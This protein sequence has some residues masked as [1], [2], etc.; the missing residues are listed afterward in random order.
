[1]HTVDA[2]PQPAP[3]SAVGSAWNKA[4]TY[5]ETILTPWASAYL[6]E[7]LETISVQFSGGSVIV[8]PLPEGKKKNKKSKDSKEKEKEDDKEETNEVVDNL[9]YFC[10][11][12]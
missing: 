11:T 12:T 9:T 3:S 7:Q 10:R 6:K 8:K 4:G 1:M 2:L 5:E